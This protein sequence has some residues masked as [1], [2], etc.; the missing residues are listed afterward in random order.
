MGEALFEI[1]PDIRVARTL[2][3]RVYSDPEIFRLQREHL[4]ARTWHYAGHDDLVKVAGQVHPFALLPGALDEPLLLT[5]DHKDQIHCL[6][7]VCTHRGTLVVEGAGHEQQLRCR[8]HGRRFALDG[9]FHSMP[10]FESTANFPSPSDDLPRVEL[11]SWTRFLMVSL[12]PAMEFDD[13]VAPM[14]ERLD[15]LPFHV[16]AFDASG[17]RDYFVKA[18]WA[19]YLDNYLEGF[20]IPYV[21]SSLSTTLDSGEYTVELE[22]FSVLQLGIAKPGEPA[23]ALPPEHRDH[24]RAVA[25]YYYWLFPTTMFNVYPWGVSVNVVTPLAVDRTRVSFLPFVWDAA[26]RDAG[27]GASLD[28]VEREDEAVVESVQRGVRSRLYDRGRYSPTRESG[29]HHFH[30]LLAEFMSGS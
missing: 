17:A 12:A 3:A 15:G 16:L 22:R 4:F 13:L 28:R 10:E 9:R 21:H 27:A 5:R 26:Q 7:N 18:N 29:V 19:L 30:R 23:F 20:H 14:R 11:G 24:G 8:Y 6:S 2:P 1:D 25:A